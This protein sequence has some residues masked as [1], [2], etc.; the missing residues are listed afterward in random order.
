MN[1]KHYAA[2]L[3]SITN[4]FFPNTTCKPWSNEVQRAKMICSTCLVKDECLK[5]ALLYDE[6]DGI[7]G[8]LTYMERKQVSAKNR[9]LLH[10]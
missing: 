3:N 1:N 6:P 5:M 4:V 8:G 7:W 10:Q 9:G 2:C